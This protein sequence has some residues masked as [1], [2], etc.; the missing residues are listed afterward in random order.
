[1]NI[2]LIGDKNGI[3]KIFYTPEKFISGVL[4]GNQVNITVFHNGRK[5]NNDSFEFKIKKSDESDIDYNIIEL[6]SF[7]PKFNSTLT[8]NYITR[9]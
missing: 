4:L 6:I 2:S 8:A 3:N 1:M 9:N 5:L 7:T